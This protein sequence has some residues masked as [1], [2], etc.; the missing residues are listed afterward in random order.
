[1]NFLSFSGGCGQ[2]IEEII[3]DFYDKII[4][5]SFVPDINGTQLIIFIIEWVRSWDPVSC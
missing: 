2:L 4:K 3:S 5:N 1:M